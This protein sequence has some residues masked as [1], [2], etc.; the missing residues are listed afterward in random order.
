MSEFGKEFDIDEVYKSES[1]FIGSLA[2]AEDFRHVEVPPGSPLNFDEKMLEEVCFLF[3]LPLYFFIK[4]E[5]QFVNIVALLNL[6]TL[7]N[8]ANT[9]KVSLEEISVLFNMMFVSID[10]LADQMS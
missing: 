9:A 4:D 1:S 10:F 2:S 7:T 6:S 3:A 8:M 5:Q